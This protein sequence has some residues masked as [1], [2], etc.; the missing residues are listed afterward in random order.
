MLQSN[1]EINVWFEM[2]AAG[3]ACVFDLGRGTDAALDHGH[4]AAD[5]LRESVVF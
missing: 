4:N 5:F 2:V 3:L 1:G